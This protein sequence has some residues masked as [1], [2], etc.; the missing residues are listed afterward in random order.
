MHGLHAPRELDQLGNFAPMRLVEL[1]EGSCRSDRPYRLAR[2][3]AP[4]PPPRAPGAERLGRHEVVLN[5]PLHEYVKSGNVNTTLRPHRSVLPLM[6]RNLADVGLAP[7]VR[8][9]FDPITKVGARGQVGIVLSPGSRRPDPSM[10]LSND[11]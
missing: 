10:R 2:R 6:A 9:A 7:N 3:W 5:I 4:P 11:H 1:G 8:S